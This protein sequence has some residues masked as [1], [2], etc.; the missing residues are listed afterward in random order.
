M[1]FAILSRL[2]EQEVKNVSKS[3]IFKRHLNMNFKTRKSSFAILKGFILLCAF[4]VLVSKRKAFKLFSF[5]ELVSIW[6]I[7]SLV[8]LKNKKKQQWTV[9]I[10]VE[11]IRH[12]QFKS[13]ELTTVN[14]LEQ[15]KC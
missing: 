8:K 15:L 10:S 9:K 6:Q 7:K 3:I 11:F 14:Y 2:H 13:H 5:D 4:N 12:S 1:L